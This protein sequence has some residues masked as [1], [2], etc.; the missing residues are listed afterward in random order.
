M[1][2]RRLTTGELQ[3]ME[4]EFVRFLVSNGI[5]ADDW[6]KIK[7][8]DAQQAEGLI[9]IF[10]DVVFD[11]VLEK[12]KHVEHRSPNDLKTFRFLEDKI[13]LL[14]LKVN[15]ASSIDLTKGQPLEDMLAYVQT[16]KPGSVQMYR[17]EKAYKDDNPKKEIF[18]MLE[19]GAAISDGKIFE[20]LS[21]M[22]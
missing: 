5:T 18:D 7:T 14:G 13:E 3:D 9:Q 19:S 17:A 22:K 6:V 1:K 15:D 8:E 10:S 20:A 16:A 4:N 2:Y 11:K 21:E 12:V